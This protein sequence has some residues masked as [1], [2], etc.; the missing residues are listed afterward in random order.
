[1]I[2]TIVNFW[3]RKRSAHDQF[4]DLLRPHLRRLYSLAYRFSRNPDDAED[5]VQDILLKLYPR[6]KEMQSIEKLGPWLARVLYRHYIDKLRSEQ[7]SPIQYMGDE[8]AAYETH[9]GDAVQPSELLEHEFLQQHL[10]QALNQLNDDQRIAVILHDVE[11]YS[12]Q[13]I[14]EILSVPTGTLKSRLS[15]ARDKLRTI[16][17]TMEP[18]SRQDRVKE[19]TR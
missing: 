3:P 1:M 15:R 12:L 10:Q 14:S 18:F 19:V 2:M 5:L 4:E 7:R 9:A 6:L 13:E 8:E 11:E 16:L 17:Q